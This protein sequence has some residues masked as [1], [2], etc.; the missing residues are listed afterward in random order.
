[1]QAL[2]YIQIALAVIVIIL[3]LIQERGGGISGL[4]GGDGQG[5]YQSRRGVERVI[6]FAT[7]VATVAFAGIA[8]A[9]LYFGSF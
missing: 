6:F 2:P 8:L 1:M 4:L 3:V 7:I 9:Q 5:T